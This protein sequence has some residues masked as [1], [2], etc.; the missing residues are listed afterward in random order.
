MS[1]HH[2][3]KQSKSNFFQHKTGLDNLISLKKVLCSPPMTSRPHFILTISHYLYHL[4]S[5]DLPLAAVKLVTNARSFTFK[6]RRLVA[7]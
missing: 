2:L 1:E 4:Q 6:K 7:E 3:P 5:C